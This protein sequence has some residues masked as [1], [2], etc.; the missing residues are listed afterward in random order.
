M[1]CKS[2]SFNDM[3]AHKTCCF[4]VGNTDEDWADAAIRD[5]PRLN[6]KDCQSSF[7]GG[8]DS[9]HV[10]HFLIHSF[11]LLLFGKAKAKF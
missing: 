10:L 9:I 2:N 6:S 11:P 3:S 8:K 7:S 5:E 1:L 4:I